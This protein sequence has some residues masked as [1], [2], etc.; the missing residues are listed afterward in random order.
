MLNKNDR[1]NILAEPLQPFATKHKAMADKQAAAG[2]EFQYLVETVE[3]AGQEKSLRLVGFNEKLIFP[4]YVLPTQKSA[5]KNMSN[6]F[7]NN[8]FRY[9]W[10][11]HCVLAV[12]D[13]S[14]W[15]VLW[16]M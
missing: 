11:V 9:H 5:L 13:L 10:D 8:K 16:V 14:H 6:Y 7:I 2:M 12:P 3:A 1:V 4:K 15:F